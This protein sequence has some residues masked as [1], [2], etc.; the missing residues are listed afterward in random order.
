MRARISKA[1]KFIKWASGI[2]KRCIPQP[3]T[4]I[5]HYIYLHRAN[6]SSTVRVLVSLGF[7]ASTYVVLCPT[8]QYKRVWRGRYICHF[9]SF[10]RTGQKSGWI[11]YV[12]WSFRTHCSQ[13]KCCTNMRN[14]MLCVDA[15]SDSHEWSW[16]DQLF[17]RVHC[18]FMY[19]VQ[20]QSTL[21][22]TNCLL[23]TP[24]IGL[25]YSRFCLLA[26][27]ILLS[28]NRRRAISNVDTC[29]KYCL[30][31]VWENMVPKIPIGRN[32]NLNNEWKYYRYDL[33]WY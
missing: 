27:C 16:I 15:A 11:V 12:W 14:C 1:I 31:K 19:S 17:N 29:A 10:I 7:L 2:Q 28:F 9:C 24:Q 6:V 32:N 4:P 8:I 18:T 21:T 26:P 5:S 13:V 20:H 23:N 22:T 30:H 3:T 33:R 25:L